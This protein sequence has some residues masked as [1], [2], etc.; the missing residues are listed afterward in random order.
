MTPEQPAWSEIH[1]GTIPWTTAGFSAAHAEYLRLLRTPHDDWDRGP[2]PRPI[3]PAAPDQLRLPRL[4]QMDAVEN[5]MWRYLCRTYPAASTTV[6]LSHLKR[7][8]TIRE[9]FEG[10]LDRLEADGLVVVPRDGGEPWFSSVL[11]EVVAFVRYEARS[12]D[13]A[14]N[15]RPTFNYGR[16]VRVAK[17]ILANPEQDLA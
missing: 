6:L 9:F 8:F 17:H 2:L 13:R 16:V 14:G 10:H 5:Q 7:F 11:I 15:D 1:A 3:P 4:P 12:P